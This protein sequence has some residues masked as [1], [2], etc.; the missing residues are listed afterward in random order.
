MDGALPDGSQS[1]PLIPSS[2]T[3]ILTCID[4]V[5]GAQNRRLQRDLTM[6]L[7]GS[8]SGI[9]TEMPAEPL[10]ADDPDSSE[11]ESPPSGR[12]Q[13]H[14]ED[15]DDDE[16]IV[17][18]NE[19]AGKDFPLAHRLLDKRGFVNISYLESVLHV[20]HEICL[21][22]Q[23]EEGVGLSI[24]YQMMQVLEQ[25]MS[26]PKLQV[27]SGLTKQGIWN[28]H[29]DAHLPDMF[30]RFRSTMVEELESRFHVRTTPDAPTLLALQMDPYLDTSEESGIFSDRTAAQTLMFG[31]YKRTLLRRMRAS[32]VL[33]SAPTTPAPAPAP[34][35]DPASP[36]T[37]ASPLALAASSA[38]SREQEHK[39]PPKR[40]DRHAP[41]DPR[42][43]VQEV[44]FDW[45]R[46]FEEAL[47]PL[48]YGC[49]GVGD[50]L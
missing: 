23:K 48:N 2:L 9:S 30:R 33:R 50:M 4:C 32:T 7:T 38:K 10:A 16:A 18:A 46:P 20:P 14:A 11:D 17:T 12:C 49:G 26:A 22:L 15:E 3:S 13:G 27:V 43:Q 6:A 36:A 41:P 24:S 21:L 1:V 40:K 42:I 19:V 25:V 44:S 29:H 28:E 5:C 45:G 34:A 39:Q 8:D 47:G 35:P 37:S 31:E